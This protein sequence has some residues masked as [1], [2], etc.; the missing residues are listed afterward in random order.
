MS[1]EGLTQVIPLPLPPIPKLLFAADKWDG[2]DMGTSDA[3]HSGMAF[4]SMQIAV[5]VLEL[6]FSCDTRCSASRSCL[7]DAARSWGA[8]TPPMRCL[9]VAVGSVCAS[10]DFRFVPAG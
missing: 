4:G 7:W 10:L 2:N 5:C 6:N 8:S 3:C 9:G 1:E